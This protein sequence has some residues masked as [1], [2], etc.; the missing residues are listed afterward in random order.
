M[1]YITPFIIWPLLYLL[2]N[3][4]IFNKNNNIVKFSLARNFIGLMNSLLCCTGIAGYYLFN[5]Q[6]YYDYSLLIPISY[7][8][9]DT[10]II[11]VKDIYN[12]IAYIIHHILAIILLYELLFAEMLLI[13]LLYPVLLSIEIS[14]ISIYLTYH[15]IKTNP[16]NT[17]IKVK[18]VLFAKS[19]QLFIY[20]LIRILYYTYLTIYVL[21]YIPRSNYFKSII[22][23][24]YFMGLAWFYNQFLGLYNGLV[25][26]KT[27]NTNLIKQQTKIIK[28]VQRNN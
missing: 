16:P 3:H 7:Y 19:I 5:K 12:E 24:I 8:V 13:N 20:F 4:Y 18:R 22:L 11:I 9:W 21:P 6:K 25:N 23:I 28:G 26:P 15:V 27:N 10:Y 1:Y 14:N 17:L 2:S